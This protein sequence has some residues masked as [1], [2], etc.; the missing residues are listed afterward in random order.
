MKREENIRK[1]TRIVALFSSTQ[2][3]YEDSKYIIL[4]VIG[5]KVKGRR[6]R[7]AKLKALLFVKRLFIWM[8]LR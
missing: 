4:I 5:Y 1:T 8:S 2:A 3:Y 6:K 7:E